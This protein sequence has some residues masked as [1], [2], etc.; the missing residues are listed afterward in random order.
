MQNKDLKN[1]TLS[2]LE[3]IL[4]AFQEKKFIAKNIFQ[5]IHQKNI[6]NINDFSNVSKD[7]RQKLI[8]NGYYISELKIL[9]K[10]EDSDG[11]IKY[12]FGLPDGNRIETVLLNDKGRIT[13]C[14]S[15]QVGC[16]FNCSFC[17]TGKLRFIRDLTAGE[18]IDQVIQVE[19]SIPLHLGEGGR[20]PGEGKISNIVYMGMGEPLDNYEEVMR[21]VYI[22]NDKLGKN[23]GARSITIST[24]GVIPGIEKLSGEKLQI[25]L[26]ISLHGHT[27]NI[28]NKIMPINKRYPVADLIKAVRT[29]QQ[30]TNRR[31]TFEYILLE[32]INDSRECARGLLKLINGI[33]AHV[34]LIEFNDFSGAQFKAPPRKQI[35]EF[36]WIIADRGFEVNIRFKRGRE[37]MAA[38]GQLGSISN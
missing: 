19:K 27:D 22:L 17:A 25:R 9:K 26:A 34:N 23:I 31:V 18:I 11:S 36:Q 8:N 21:S 32:G 12:L 20:R 6:S 10:L 16:K 2:E 35:K 24:S 1:M 7:S 30:K 37:I 28:R 14:I 5:W 3:A 33:K 15:S 29:Y 4:V 13:L 38:C